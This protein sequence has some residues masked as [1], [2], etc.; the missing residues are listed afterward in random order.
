MKQEFQVW[1]GPTHPKTPHYV[2]ANIKK[3]KKSEIR[4]TPGPKH[5][6]KRHSTLNYISILLLKVQYSLVNATR[7]EENRK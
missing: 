4:D 5:L 2:Y 3:K 6:G 7:S 1:T